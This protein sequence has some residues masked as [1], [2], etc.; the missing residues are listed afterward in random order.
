MD[1]LT[2]SLLN[3]YLVLAVYFEL[4]WRKWENAVIVAKTCA[5]LEHQSQSS[6]VIN[7]LRSSVRS[8]FIPTQM[9]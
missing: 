5:P 2:M 8:Y 4:Q 6:Q 3:F 9:G 1:K 7:L